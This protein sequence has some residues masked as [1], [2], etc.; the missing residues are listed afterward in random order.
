M[1]MKHSLFLK[2]AG[3]FVMHA[4]IILCW[5]MPAKA[6]TTYTVTDLGSGATGAFET[7]A[8]D[9][10]IRGEAVAETIQS[11]S[12]GF[13]TI[14]FVSKNGQITLLPS[15]GGQ[16]TFAGA[17][18]ASG[19]VAGS[20]HLAGDT[21]IHATIWDRDLNHITDL[22]TLGGSISAALWLNDRNQA[23]GDSVTSNGVDIHGF[24]WDRG[25]L[26]DLGTL[27]G[28][29]S[30]PFGINNSGLVIGQADTTTALDPLFGIPTFHGF[31]WDRGV[32]RD[33]G[34]I[35]GGH[36]NYAQSVNERGD[37]VGAA[38]LAGDLTAHAFMI[39]NASLIDLGV[40]PG[41]TN[42]AAFGVNNRGQVV[43]ISAL[44]IDPPPAPPSINFLCPCHAAIWQDG[45]A[46]DLNTL[47]PPGS[48]WQ[49]ILAIAIN[50]RGQIVGNGMLNNEFRA[51]LLTPNNSS[52]MSSVSDGVM[53][54][55]APAAMGKV[56]GPSA[57]RATIV[58]GKRRLVLEH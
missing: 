12:P 35:F 24:L 36:F 54:N 31:R 56:E 51:F 38:D 27:G 58:N 13:K 47:I 28:S 4:S 57:I 48:G 26:V 20:S 25:T 55:Q 44:F 52:S 50:D 29:T 8:D 32:L 40:A 7:T 3:T 45:A 11:L 41:D 30:F 9:I 6:Q 22:G 1:I 21:I 2:T 5:V 14:G 18:N 43:G 15:L 53:T 17:I 33:L 42:S 37:I 34:E 10:N 46:T 23:V 16:S 49:L 19:V 39:R